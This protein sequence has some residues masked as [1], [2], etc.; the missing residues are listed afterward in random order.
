[1]QPASRGQE[2]V[3]Y[4]PHNLH[5]RSVNIS[6]IKLLKSKNGESTHECEGVIEASGGRSDEDRLR[7]PRKRTRV[8]RVAG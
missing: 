1:M 2:G 7:P 8:L 6:L 3:V 4:P 5:F